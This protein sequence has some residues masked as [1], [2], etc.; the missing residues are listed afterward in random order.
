MKRQ[1]AAFEQSS[2]R[3][4]V[5][6]FTRLGGETYMSQQGMKRTFPIALQDR[7]TIAPAPANWPFP[8]APDPAL[9][10]R[11]AMSGGTRTNWRALRVVGLTAGR[12]ERLAALY[13]FQNG[14]ASPD[15]ALAFVDG[16]NE[17]FVTD[18]AE[19]DWSG[20][21]LIDAL[22]AVA[23]DEIRRLRNLFGAGGPASVRRV[24][25]PN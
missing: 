25:R 4:S 11:P 24:S 23:A 18:P 20:F 3:S 16:A 7:E 9:A 2:S 17:V 12:S 22:E 8:S 19:V 15:L 13:R 10:S 5:H 6:D 21:P 1:K 14:E